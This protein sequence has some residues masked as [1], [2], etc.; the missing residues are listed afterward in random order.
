MSWAEAFSDP[1]GAGR[2]SSASIVGCA[3]SLS[4]PL[5]QFAHR[6]LFGRGVAADQLCWTAM[7]A[8]GCCGIS[9]VG[10]LRA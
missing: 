7:S 2:S 5:V 8:A 6:P 1:P 3:M 4:L 9:F 10:R